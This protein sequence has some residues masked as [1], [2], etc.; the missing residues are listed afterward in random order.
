MPLGEYVSFMLNM[1]TNQEVIKLQRLQ[2]RALR[3]CFDVYNPMEISSNKLHI[4]EKVSLLKERRDLNLL[5]LMYEMKQLHV[6][7]QIGDRA[8]RQGDKYV[9][10]MDKSV[11]GAYVQSPY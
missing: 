5:C 8:T 1:N 2:N 11:V 4:R 6:Y 9:F 10:Q 7:E 3:M